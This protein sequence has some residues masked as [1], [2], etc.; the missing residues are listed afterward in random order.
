MELR[1]TTLIVFISKIFGSI[2]TFIATI[3]FARRLG[4]SILGQ[5]YTI[6][7]L[8][9]WLTLVGESGILNAIR[10]R[11]SERQG[12]YAYITAG[13]IIVTV[14]SISTAVI[15][16]IF[17]DLINRYVGSN[18]TY[19]LTILVFFRLMGSFIQVALDGQDLVHISGIL[20]SFR[21]AAQTVIQL[22]FIILGIGLL[23]L[24]YGILLSLVITIPLGLYFLKFRLEM[25]RKRHIYSLVD[26]AKYSWLGR[27]KSK[28]FRQ[29][30]III[31]GMFASSETVGIYSIGWT[32]AAFFHFFSSSISKSVFPRLSNISSNGSV[33][34]SADIITLSMGY[35]GLFAFPGLVGGFILRHKLLQVYGAEF[36]NASEVLVILIGSVLLYSFYTQCVNGL[37]GINRPDLSFNSN[38]VFITSN[39]ILNLILGWKFGMIGVATASLISILIGLLFAYWTLSKI[40]RISFPSRIIMKQIISSVIMGAVVYILS[41]S[42]FVSEITNN[43]LLNII[44]LVL[45]GALIYFTIL[46]YMSEDLRSGHLDGIY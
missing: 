26:Y 8:L 28:S 18:V 34:S 5:Y 3:Y 35:S 39:I 27:I 15:L 37:A 19:L 1:K 41:I 23:G 25:P 10:K 11:V 9:A 45:V 21:Q 38:A 36:V 46:L 22:L 17:R 43:N 13:I 14:I 4:A 40:V 20:Q 33:N 2:F 42:N 29:S 24:L 7:A 16:I 6:I 31:L 30:D 44:A 32:V 12:Q